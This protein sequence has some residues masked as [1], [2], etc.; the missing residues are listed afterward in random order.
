MEALNFVPTGEQSRRTILGQI[1][2]QNPLK[3]LSL[4]KSG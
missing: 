3:K 1:W 2:R 4:T